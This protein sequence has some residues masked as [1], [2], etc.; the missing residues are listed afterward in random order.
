VRFAFS[1]FGNAVAGLAGE[2]AG[3]FERERCE[4]VNMY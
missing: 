2:R 4:E 3:T 1:F